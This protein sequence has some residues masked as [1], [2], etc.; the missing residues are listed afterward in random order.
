MIVLNDEHRRMVEQDYRYRG[1]VFLM[2][3]GVDDE[4]FELPRKPGESLN[5]LFVGRLS[6][7]KNL[8]ALFEALGKIDTE[9]TV[10]VIGDGECR[11]GLEELI[12]RNSLGNV[13]LHGRL[14]RA[15]IMNFYSTASALIL[16]SLYEAQP[17]VLLEAMACRVPVIC[18]RVVGVEPIA[19]DVAILVDPTVTG[20][21]QGIKSF[22]DMSAVDMQR[23]AEAAF[24]RAEGYR[25]KALIDAC[26]EMYEEV[27]AG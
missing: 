3:N 18:T 16:P 26:V 1:K 27:A 2:S 23:M 10:D 22:I 17:V 25:W 15:Q 4:F 24:T 13:T 20:I 5:L 6:P 19:R 8:T 12:D 21:H 9:M 11:D 14:S 7:Q